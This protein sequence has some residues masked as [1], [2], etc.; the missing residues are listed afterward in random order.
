M[1]EKTLLIIK[2]DG[3]KRKLIGEVISRLEKNNFDILNIKFLHLSLKEAKEFYKIHQGKDFY[4]SL[5]QFM[6][7]GPIVA[8]LLAGE[9]ALHRLRE[10]V[11]A[12]DPKKAQKGTIRGDLGTSI[13][14]NVVHAANP[15]ENVE[16]EIKFFFPEEKL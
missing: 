4:E 6:A 11:G 12:T 10:L 5:C 9:N 14:E 13:Q 3:V 16:R 8:I 2:P 1:K 7:S 15:E